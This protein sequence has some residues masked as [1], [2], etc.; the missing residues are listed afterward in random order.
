MLRGMG[1]VVCVLVLAAVTGAAA[2]AVIVSGTVQQVDHPAGVIILHDGR[3]V[4]VGSTTRVVT[5]AGQPV[6]LAAVQPGL[7]VTIHNGEPVAIR[8]GRYVVLAPGPTA[9]PTVV[10][11][12]PV[13]TTT[14]VTTGPPAVGVVTEAGRALYQT[15]GR[16]SL[17]DRV[18]QSLTFDDGRIVYLTEDTQLLIEN[19]QPA[20]IDAVTPGMLVT[21]RSLTPFY[22]SRRDSLDRPVAVT[23]VPPATVAAVPPGPV[24]GTVVQVAPDAI[25]LSDGRVIRTT[26]RT[27][28]VVDNQAVAPVAVHPGTQVVI[29]PDGTRVLVTGEGLPAASPP[30]LTSGAGLRQRDNS[31]QTP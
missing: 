5:T 23:T 11:P 4:R 27:V 30:T 13:P 9:A 21:V 2:Q 29:Y 16:V 12:A 15:S 6:T 19:Y 20:S 31:R 10:A 26:P 8:D 3:M 17:V 1:F 22:Y 28:V 25:V 24:S 18:R 7:A 14:V